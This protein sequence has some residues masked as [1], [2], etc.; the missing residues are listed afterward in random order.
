MLQL[1][2]LRAALG[3]FSV[4]RGHL[5][6]FSAKDGRKKKDAGG[7]YKIINY[8]GKGETRE[9]AERANSI[10]TNQIK[11]Y[12]EEAART[13]RSHAEFARQFPTKTEEETRVKA[14][15]RE[16]RDAT[17]KTHVERLKK[18]LNPPVAQLQQSGKIPR[19]NP[20]KRAAKVARG[21]VNLLQSQKYV[22]LMRRKYL[23][24]LSTDVA[25]AL[26]TEANLDAKILAALEA[27]VSHNLSAETVVQ[28]VKDF[29]LKLKAIRVPMPEYADVVE[30]GTDNVEN[31]GKMA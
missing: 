25:P 31:V 13:R 28:K 6:A 24:L 19:P 7:G 17:W 1:A 10:R 18:H 11:V 21:Q 4:L 3:N 22:N 23:N 8:H 30:E 26:V 9:A 2:K 27:P 16:K 29:K 12:Q 20:E 14:A 5:R 15:R